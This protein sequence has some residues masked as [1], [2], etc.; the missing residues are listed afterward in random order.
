MEKTGWESV[1]QDVVPSIVASRSTSLSL[2]RYGLRCQSCDLTFEDDGFALECPGQH[3][4]ALLST[5][6]REK[7]FEPNTGAEGLFRYRK[8][9]PGRRT[10]TGAGRVIDPRGV[11]CVS[12]AVGDAEIDQFVDSLR[13]VLRTLASP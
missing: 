10:L 9:L 3:E 11:G 12:A 6:Y 4:P 2:P 13:T 5:R 7:Q 1:V 8:W